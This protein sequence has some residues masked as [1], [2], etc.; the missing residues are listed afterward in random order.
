MEECL[1][2]GHPRVMRIMHKLANLY[3]DQNDF[4]K[5]IAL[6]ERL[7]E[8]RK[9]RLGSGHPDILRTY[10][11]AATLYTLM[12]KYIEAE[13]CYRLELAGSTEELGVLHPETKK[14]ELHLA[15]FLRDQELQGKV[16]LC[17]VHD[18]V[19]TQEASRIHY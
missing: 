5:S 8:L 3:R 7:L 17:E 11:D 18:A 13:Q 15:T 2:H 9:T 4:I 12:G 1:G 14:R 10:H 16:A 6:F 19:A